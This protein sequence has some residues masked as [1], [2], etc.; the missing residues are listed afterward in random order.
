MAKVKE[1]KPTDK[2]ADKTAMTKFLQG[3]FGDAQKKVLKRLYKRV[4]DIN[5]LE[6]KYQEMSKKELAEQTEI[7]KARLDE[8]TK[9]EQGKLALAKIKQS[10]SKKKEAT[11]AS[12]A[13]LEKALNEILPDAFA[14]VREST[15][16]ILGMRHFDVQLIGGMVLHEEMLQK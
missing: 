11:D 7:L 5:K 14:L 1:K 8:L 4:I 12:D 3:I 9:K 13:A 16:R 15:N 6:P 10:K 2:L